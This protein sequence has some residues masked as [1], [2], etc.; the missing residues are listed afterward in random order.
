MNAKIPHP[1]INKM[2]SVIDHLPP[3]RVLHT[4]LHKLLE[5]R[6][7]TV[8]PILELI[9]VWLNGSRNSLD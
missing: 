7:I 9:E 5:G 1:S 8:I 2:S 4:D 6:V 3:F